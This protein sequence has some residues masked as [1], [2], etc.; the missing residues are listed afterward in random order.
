MKNKD[1]SYLIIEGQRVLQRAAFKKIC[2]TFLPGICS[3]HGVWTFSSSQEA[4][5]RTASLKRSNQVRGL[6]H[7][8][9]VSSCPM[10]LGFK[11]TL[12]Y[13]SAAMEM[14][15]FLSFLL[16]R[17]FLFSI[18]PIHGM[19]QVATD[20]FMTSTS[21]KQILFPKFPTAAWK[22]RSV[23]YTTSSCVPSGVR[24]NACRLCRFIESHISLPAVWHSV[25]SHDKHPNHPTLLC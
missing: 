3:P 8:R 21:S 9:S 12:P 25:G 4:G 7:S 10:K 20:I 6:R 1:S 24:L 2:K 14:N 15:L 11:S 22:R 23:L 17:Q 13:P 19:N 5:S 16:F 18:Y